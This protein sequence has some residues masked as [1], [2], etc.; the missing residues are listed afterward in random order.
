M[1]EPMALIERILLVESD[2]DISD[3]IA[4]QALRPLG[5]QVDIVTD[6]G[7]AIKKALQTPPDLV[8]ANL[9]LPGLSG[10]DLLVALS[11][12]GSTA[13]LIVIAGKGQE[14]DVIQAFRLGAND[15]LLW[16]AREAEVVS[17]VERV[18]T[19]VREMRARRRLDE[20]LKAAN[21]ELQRKVRELTFIVAVG[22]AV[23]SITDRRVLFERIVEGALQVAGADLGWLLLRDDRA[24]TFLLTAQRNLPEAWAK[25]MG[26]P[27][28]DGI[29]ALVALS[30]ESLL[31]HGDPLQK[32]KV[33][34]LGRSAAVTPIK[35]RNEVIG[36]MIVVR[37][38][39]KAF[40]ET[41]QTLL[42]A[43]ADYA[44]ISLVNERLFRAIQQNAEAARSGEKQQNELFQ[45]LRR[46]AQKELDGIL[47]PL[48]LILTGKTGPLNAEQRQA[49]S[50]ANAALQRLSEVVSQN[51]PAER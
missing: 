34:A 22:K 47:Y 33:A 29:S 35:V 45:S 7:S 26:Q 31:I 20:Q 44:S 39:Q 15:V 4:R 46:S 3:L 5:Y 51:R 36:L 17:A 23:V 43:V 41:E 1:A 40:G 13:P 28:D 42:E 6:A 30:G 12:Q 37:R 9:N 11:S 25:K 32:F 10:K 38:A 49:L 21:D 16:P 27:L 50:S 18:L 8:I 19:Q 48:G 2:P 24:K 14:Q